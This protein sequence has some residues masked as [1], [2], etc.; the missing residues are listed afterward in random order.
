M[1]ILVTAGDF[2]PALARRQ[3]HFIYWF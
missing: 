1:L 2:G 3:K